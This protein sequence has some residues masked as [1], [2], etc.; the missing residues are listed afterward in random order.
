M[1]RRWM[2]ISLKGLFSLAAVEAPAR[3]GQATGSF[4]IGT[5]PSARGHSKAAR[6]TDAGM[7]TG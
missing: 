6:G 3:G 5:G 2:R 1:P 7:S 4:A